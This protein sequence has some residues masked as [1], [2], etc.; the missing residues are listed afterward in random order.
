MRTSSWLAAG[1]LVVVFAACG[2]DEGSSVAPIDTAGAAGASGANAA[3]AAGS[4]AAGAAGSSA[5]GAAGSS[6]AGSS[7]AGAAG[8]T[9]GAGAGGCAIDADCAGAVPTTNPADCAEGY[10]KA[11]AC[12][13]RAKDTDGDGF[14]RSKCAV[15]SDD[16]VKI[17]LGND[18][19]DG[20]ANTN[21][22]AW[23]GPAADGHPD[24]CGD[25]IDQNCSGQDGDQ[26]GTNGASCACVPDDVATCGE[27]SNGAPISF[28]GGMPAVGSECKLGS[29]TCVKDVI[30]GGKWGPCIGA[31]PPSVEICDTKDNDCDGNI[32]ESDDAQGLL[33]WSYDG[34]GDGRAAID[35]ATKQPFATVLSCKKP[36][37]I[38]VECT[39][40]YCGSTPIET[41][42]PASAWATDLQ[43]QDCDDRQ[44]SV[45]PGATELCGDTIDSDCDG[46]LDNGYSLGD[47]CDLSF[48]A[49]KGACQGGGFRR[50]V[51]AGV[52]TT[53]CRREDA[54]IGA[55]TTCSTVASATG[56]DF[57]CDGAVTPCTR[58]CTSVKAGVCSCSPSTT[59]DRTVKI[60]QDWTQQYKGA[61]TE[62][63]I[64]HPT[65]PTRDTCAEI[66]SKLECGPQKMFVDCGDILNPAACTP[67]NCARTCKDPCGQAVVTL[68]CSWNTVSGTCSGSVSPA[69]TYCG[70]TGDKIGCK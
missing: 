5:A 57:N 61:A 11:G 4:N 58:V 40:A 19:D 26:V 8:A 24:H 67:L 53:E 7:G 63:F 13:V 32:D 50:C 9:A 56:F 3:G 45:F 31:V 1:S 65:D 28:P 59:T 35:P 21:P 36:D 27:T 62:P 42:C 20:D 46:N 38:P 70:G 66:K 34:D 51:G 43:P 17:E 2:G 52:T 15:I 16:P 12:A 49:G 6:A 48:G 69:P 39:A 33:T 64:V 25:G 10:C 14:R 47:A 23:D 55:D 22:A 68:G 44:K 60:T 37:Q 29:K 30:N 18:C 54:R 41:C